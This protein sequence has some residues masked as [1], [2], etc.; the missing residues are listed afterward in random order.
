MVST[1]DGEVLDI[2]TIFDNE[3]ELLKAKNCDAFLYDT[4][5]KY[6]IDLDHAIMRA[7]QKHFVYKIFD[8]D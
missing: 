2:F 7:A 5:E 4:P 1:E 8:E 6:G 3:K